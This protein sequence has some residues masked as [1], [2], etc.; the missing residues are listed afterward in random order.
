[1]INIDISWLKKEPYKINFLYH[2]THV[3]NLK[4]VH[5]LGL[6]SRSRTSEEGYTTT[7]IANLEVLN[8]RK[9]K[10]VPISGRRLPD[11]VPLF[12]T[13]QAPMLYSD[14]VTPVQ[15]ETAILCLDYS[16]L[17]RRDVIFTDGNASSYRTRFFNDLR[18]IDC[19]DWTNCI[20]DRSN[21]IHFYSQQEFDEWKRKRAAEILVPDW[22]SFTHV[23]SIVVKN[24][25]VRQRLYNPVQGITKVDARFYSGSEL[26]FHFDD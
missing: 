10:V 13:P 8:R 15:D 22:I 14:E 5:N 19:L 9:Q 20:R 2:L 21:P 7:Q 16:L 6:H 23:K 4:S 24:Q 11:Y 18:F 17:L 1:M 3:D 25:P 26:R 12:F